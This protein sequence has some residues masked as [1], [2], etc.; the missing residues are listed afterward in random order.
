[1]GNI[2]YRGQA[3]D[4]AALAAAEAH[5]KRM[6]HSGA[7]RRVRDAEPLV[8]GS[9]DL[10]AAFDAHTANVKKNKAAKKVVLHSIVQFPVEWKIT[11]EIEKQMLA[12]AVEFINETHGGN[13][14]FA[15]RL[16]RDEKGRHTV[17][18]FATPLYVKQ[19]AKRKT[20][21][22]W[23]S[24]TK[25][26]KE[27]CKKHE[28]EIKSRNSENKFSTTPR[29]VGIAMQS[30]LFQFLRKKYG[31][32][33]KI[34]NKKK[35]WGKDWLSPEAYQL[36]KAQRQLEKLAKALKKSKANM[37]HFTQEL[38]EEFHLIS[39]EGQR[40]FFNGF[41]KIGTLPEDAKIEQ[42]IDVQQQVEAQALPSEKTDDLYTPDDEVI[43]QRLNL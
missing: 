41:R 36:N 11:P 38:L 14:V 16:D 1:M 7:V 31:T 21:E 43:N 6:D 27:I 19:N 30:E 34:K 33:I 24:C 23:M 18:V 25:H 3:I 35:T 8:Y 9:M 22:V 37:K 29:S 42:L 40:R 10:R 39:P 28:A 15:A 13:A 20:A 2:S 12:D 17:D 5:G 4:L 32:D 26:G